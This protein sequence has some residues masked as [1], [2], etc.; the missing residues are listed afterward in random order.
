MND[1]TTTLSQVK[2]QM[3]VFVDERDWQQ[4][5]APKNLSMSLAIEAAELMEHFQWISTEES[6]SPSAE[7]KV[8]IGE[9]LADVI[10]Y[11][12]AMAN[13][14]KLDIATI[15]ADKMKKNAIKYPAEEYKGRF[16]ADDVSPTTK[17][18]L[19]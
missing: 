14:L 19:H 1:D 18:K 5:H 2:K 7:K 15:F 10:C 16:G 13:E 4:F 9:E 3:R 17:T 8:Q 12:V 6:R 11:A